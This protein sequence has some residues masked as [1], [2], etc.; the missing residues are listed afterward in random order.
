MSE[1]I[2]L[3]DCDGV[4]LDFES[5]IKGYLSMFGY[6]SDVVDESL[7]DMGNR[8]GLYDSGMTRE[9][10]KQ[11]FNSFSND[12]FEMSSMSSYLDAEEYLP[13]LNREMG[14][15][16]WAI[17]AI[18]TSF[19]TQ[20]GRCINLRQLFGDLFV[21]DPSNTNISSMENGR[22]TFVEPSFTTTP[23][24]KRSVLEKFA[25]KYP[26]AIWVED[27]AHNAD[28]GHELGFRTFLIKHDYNNSYNG[29]CT[30]VN[31]WKEIHNI[32]KED[33]S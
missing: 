20:T 2:I 9:E 22:V 13:K 14:Y 21:K 24:D 23:T 17:T 4:I 26:G 32:I 29:P 8:Y 19:D 12:D 11:L 18:G 30:V 1:K 7:Y 28:I 10:V 27:A 6:P 25:N 16:F 15:S 3:T 31:N 5:A 33:E